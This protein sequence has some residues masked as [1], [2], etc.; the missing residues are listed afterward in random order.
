MDH[1]GSF[2]GLPE[3]PNLAVY[4]EVF[5]SQVALNAVDAYLE[6]MVSKIVKR[7]KGEIEAEGLGALHR[8]LESEEGVVET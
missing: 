4:R 2:Y 5:K 8:L 3:D 6:R 1:E 7:V